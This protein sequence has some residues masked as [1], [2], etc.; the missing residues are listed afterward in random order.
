MISSLL[1]ALL[2]S[3]P[4]AAPSPPS[5]L[6][7]LASSRFDSVEDFR[8]LEAEY[9]LAQKAN[10][11]K[12][13]AAQKEGKSVSRD[14]F[15]APAKDF[16]PR[17]R[18]FADEY[19]GTEGGG[20]ALL[21]VFDLASNLDD[22]KAMESAAGELVAEYVEM[23]FME[24]FAAGL[25]SAAYSVGKEAGETHLKTLLEKNKLPGVQAASLFSLAS[26]YNEWESPDRAAEG[27]KLFDQLLATYPDTT[28]AKKA[29][30]VIFEAE[31]LQVGMQAPDFSIADENGLAWKLSDYRGKVTVIDY[32]GYW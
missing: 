32:W 17:F 1:V 20:R 21:A 25:Q 15:Y 19:Q 11:E 12:L 8:A 28:Y 5:A 10:R 24:D 30:G 3:P 23:A 16:L 14:D 9:D 26:L 13:R 4:A 6:A 18:A 29:Q 31:H 27:R 7:A 22:A 2:A